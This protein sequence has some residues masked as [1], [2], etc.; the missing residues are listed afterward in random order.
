MSILDS[1]RLKIPVI[2]NL[3]IENMNFDVRINDKTV[4]STCLV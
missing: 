1:N 3:Y 2:I 4:R